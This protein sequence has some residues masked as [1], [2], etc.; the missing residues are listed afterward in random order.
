MRF[1][2]RLE[3]LRGSVCSLSCPHPR[4]NAGLLLPW[5]HS[6]QVSALFPVFAVLER[7]TTGTYEGSMDARF[8]KLTV[9]VTESRLAR[10][11]GITLAL[12]A[13]LSVPEGTLF[14]KRMRPLH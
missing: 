3:A 1:L 12:A 2:S 4:S 9:R 13:L 6:L 14:L 7:Q 10:L 8:A 5:F 11:K